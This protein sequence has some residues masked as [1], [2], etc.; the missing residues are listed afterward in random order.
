MQPNTKFQSPPSSSSSSSSS[1]FKNELI[2][3]ICV[4]NSIWSRNGDYTPNNRMVSQH[5]AILQYANALNKAGIIYTLYLIGMANEVPTVLTILSTKSPTNFNLNNIK[6]D[7]EECKLKHTLSLCKLI[8]ANKL[9]P[10]NQYQKKILLFI[11][12]PTENYTMDDIS[13][14][15]T[16]FKENNVCLEFATF[17]NSDHQ[18]FRQIFQ[19]VDSV[20]NK[21]I[22]N[23]IKPNN[24]LVVPSLVK[25]A[26][27][28]G[29]IHERSNLSVFYKKPPAISSLLNNSKQ[30][31]RTNVMNFL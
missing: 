10:P 8:L 22:F 4:D 25:L 27:I 11:G 12:S 16:F 17:G 23:Y 19:F 2:S 9:E 6:I 13:E 7:G 24:H 1:N 30:M 20:N 21:C 5:L 26:W 31:N 14:E 28:N 3:I 15:L 29:C 18:G